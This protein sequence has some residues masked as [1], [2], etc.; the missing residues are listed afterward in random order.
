MQFYVIGDEETVL[1]FSLCGVE[2]RVVSTRTECV[3]AVRSALSRRDVGIV[4]VTERVANLAR[5][6]LESLIY[7]ATFPLVLEIPDRRGPLE[8]RPTVRELARSA[9]GVSV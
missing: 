9:I 4:L 6:L 7:G 3:E 2:G 5:D 8:G 1:G